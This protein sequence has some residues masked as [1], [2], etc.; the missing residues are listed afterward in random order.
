MAKE[1]HVMHDRTGWE[2]IGAGPRYINGRNY[3][4]LVE[5]RRLCKTCEAPFSIFVTERI[6]QGLADTN[7]FAMRNCQ[8]HRRGS[9]NVELDA[10][11][12]KISVMSEEMN[13]LY[14]TER[15]LRAKIAMLE[16]K[17]KPQ[18]LPWEA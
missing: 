15:E 7:N 1:P 18:K 11:R 16:A 9:G 13:G 2:K 6:A 12:S 14:V 10:T 4:H 8:R 17:N 5:F 3:P